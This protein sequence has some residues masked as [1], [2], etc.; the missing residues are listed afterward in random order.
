M[1]PASRK[2]VDMIKRSS[3]HWA[4]WEPIIPIEVGQYGQINSETG[5]F[6]V[7]G[8]IYTN[9]AILA[10]MPILNEPAGKPVVDHEEGS[11]V[12]CSETMSGSTL[13]AVPGVDL[14][15]LVGA[16]VKVQFQI[17]DNR[18]GAFY[19]MSRPQTTYLP[20]ELPLKLLRLP[21]LKKV[22][23]VDS[24]IKC[25]AYALCLTDKNTQNISV[26]LFGNLPLAAVG[27]PVPVSLSAEGN[28]TWWTDKRT[29]MFRDACNPEGTPKYTTL[30]KTKVMSGRWR[31]WFDNVFREERPS[32]DIPLID[33][34]AVP[35]APLDEDGNEEGGGDYEDIIPDDDDD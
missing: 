21:E 5:A 34:G 2:F 12:I 20:R 26:A 31:D 17:K 4:N 13:E 32:D 33:D 35:W 9:D 29:A 22:H 1:A 27:A 10:A 24:V 14:A 11:M 19:V 30:F 28:A 25:P 23:L 8:N 15:S 7:E 3:S 18:V 6:E 16:S